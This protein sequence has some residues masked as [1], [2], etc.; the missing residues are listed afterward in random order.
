MIFFDHFVLGSKLLS[1]LFF[2]LF[3]L[4]YCVKRLHFSLILNSPNFDLKTSSIP[5]DSSL[6]NNEHTNCTER[7]LQFRS[8]TR[9]PL[10]ATHTG[11]QF[12]RA[13][14]YRAACQ[15]AAIMWR[16]WTARLL[17]FPPVRRRIPCSGAETKWQESAHISREASP[18]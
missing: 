11:T 17:V 1:R 5:G 9:R 10:T 6:Q 18:N 12:F 15:V 16:G 8:H 4:L 7:T 14:D 13:T 3:S 2:S